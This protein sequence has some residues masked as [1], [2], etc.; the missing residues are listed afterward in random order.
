MSLLFTECTMYRCLHGCCFCFIKVAGL[1]AR[2][3][4]GRLMLQNRPVQNTLR[5]QAL[6]IMVAQFLQRAWR[7]LLST[8]RIMQ[9]SLREHGTAR[10]L[11][12]SQHALVA[13]PVAQ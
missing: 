6:S 5:G 12:C 11:E 2:T 10:R 9:V 3:P 8:L 13:L 7:A 4:V 1:R